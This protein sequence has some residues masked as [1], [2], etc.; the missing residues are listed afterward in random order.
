MLTHHRLSKRFAPQNNLTENYR[1]TCQT[2]KS[3]Q[4]NPIRFMEALPP[5]WPSLPLTE[6]DADYETEA[7]TET[8][9]GTFPETF[10]PFQMD[11]ACNPKNPGLCG[12][13]YPGAASCYRSSALSDLSDFSDLS[14]LSNLSNVT[15]VQQCC[16]GSDYRLLVGPP[17][18]GRLEIN[19]SG[20]GKL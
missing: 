3:I 15:I 19:N 12:F 14:N 17:G 18:G 1:R 10:G 11:S 20:Q 13:L 5:C 4:P 7:E 6:T 8:G 16:Y 2:W 9:T